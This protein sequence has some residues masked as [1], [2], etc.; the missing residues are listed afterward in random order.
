MNKHT[1]R[2]SQ[3]FNIK[4]TR[5]ASLTAIFRRKKQAPRATEVAPTTAIMDVDPP[6]QGDRMGDINP[7]ETTFLN[8]DNG[9]DSDSDNGSDGTRENEL[10]AESDSEDEFESD[11]ECVDEEDGHRS[12]HRILDFELKAA[13]AGSIF[14]VSRVS[15]DRWLTMTSQQGPL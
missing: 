6:E 11:D 5:L 1:R 9:T 12:S 15:S 13:E 8:D 7:R 4:T 2:H 14:T 3:Q 10:V